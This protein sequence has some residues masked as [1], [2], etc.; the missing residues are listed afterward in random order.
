MTLTISPHHANTLSLSQTFANVTSISLTSGV[1]VAF[2]GTTPVTPAGTTVFEVN[3]SGDVTMGPGLL[4]GTLTG[5][6]SLLLPKGVLWSSY[7][8]ALYVQNALQIAAVGDPPELNFVAP[9]GATYPD[10]PPVQSVA[11]QSLGTIR[12]SGWFS[13]SGQ[14]GHSAAINAKAAEDITLTAS[15]GYLQFSTTP[16]GTT[17]ITLALTIWAD[18]TFMFGTN[19]DAFLRY[20]AA[21]TLKLANG[22]G[23][24]T[25]LWAPGGLATLVKAGTIGDSDFAAGMRQS[26]ALGVDTT[27]S[28]LSGRVGSTW[29]YAPLI[30][31]APTAATVDNVT[32][33]TAGTFYD[34]ASLSLDAGTWLVVGRCDVQQGAAGAG[35]IYAELLNGAA[36]ADSTRTDTGASYHGNSTVGALLVLSAT[37]TVKVRG[38]ADQAAAT[39][40]HS[41]LTA[42]QVA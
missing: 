25:G 39:L 18:Q 40:S 6:A 26:G 7:R 8:R 13:A 20:S 31:S 32:M 17:D 14:Q 29:R 21:G 5:S 27:N 35:S 23:A 30:S 9:G 38:K 12:F 28:R 42:V 41:S 3:S 24:V 19:A 22:A 4:S 11:N 33:T 34:G 2:G 36:V 1:A 10:G 16:I 37:T 15:G